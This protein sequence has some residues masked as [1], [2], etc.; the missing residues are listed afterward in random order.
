M[1]IPIFTLQQKAH[2]VTC[3]VLRGD[4][5]FVSYYKKGNHMGLSV[6][7]KSTVGGLSKEA[8]SHSL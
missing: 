7:I 4:R 8:L 1:N 5:R 3:V 6:L 2:K